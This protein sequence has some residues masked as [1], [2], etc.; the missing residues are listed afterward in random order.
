VL[1]RIIGL[2]LESAVKLR[3][4]PVSVIRIDLTQD[5]INLLFH[6]VISFFRLRRSEMEEKRKPA[7]LPEKLQKL[8]LPVF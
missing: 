8:G 4:C 7:D 6:A 1:R 2:T 3:Y 5:S